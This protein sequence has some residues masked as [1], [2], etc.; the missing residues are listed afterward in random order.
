[1]TDNC[2]H[3]TADTMPA[4]AASLDAGPISTSSQ[5]GGFGFEKPNEGNTNN[6]LTP[7]A[8]LQR[9]GRF[10]LDPCGCAGMPWST[11]TTTYFLPEHDG[12]RDPWFGRVFCNPPY[13]PNVG[14]WGRRMA[15]HANGIM[16]IFARTETKA[17]QRDVFPLADATLFLDGR[18]RFRLPSGER[19]KSG[20]CAKRP[21]RLRSK[22]RGRLAQRGHRRG[23]L[24]QGGNPD[25]HQGCA[26]LDYIVPARLPCGQAHGIAQSSGG[27]G[28]RT[29]KKLGVGTKEWTK[30]KLRLFGITILMWRSFDFPSI[31]GPWRYSRYFCGKSRYTDFILPTLY[32]YSGFSVYVEPFVGGGSVALAMAERYPNIKLILND[33]D[34]GIW[35]FWDL[36]ANAP[37]SEFQELADRT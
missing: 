13:G 5:V 10:D 1:M 12:L 4:A 14:A 17:W 27:T 22:Q 7:P 3:T 21:A 23:V 36:I 2:F 9:L 11:A 34:K 33:L 26:A 32:R 29:L 19:G 37:D 16:L 31:M 20:D 30:Y 35:A 8:L 25:W 15:D 6:W 28:N 18:V 24:P